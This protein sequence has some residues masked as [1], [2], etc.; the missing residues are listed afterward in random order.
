MA[1][2]SQQQE[3]KSKVNKRIAK[4][5]IA[6]YIRMAFAMLVSLYTSRVV[7][8][9]LGVEDFGTYGVVGGIV[10]L[11]A[12]V[13]NT[14]VGSTQRF[15][16]F[17]LGSKNDNGVT[18]V[19]SNAFH[20]QVFFSL[21]VFI[22]AETVGLY[23]LNH[24]I[25]V[26]EGRLNAANWVYQFSILITILR[27]L[28]SPFTASVVAYER[29]TVFAIVGIVNVILK[30]LIVYLLLVSPFDRLITYS[31]LGACV[32]LGVTC[33]YVYYNITRFKLCRVHHGVDKSLLKRMLS[34]SGWNIF[35][36]AAVLATFQGVDLIINYFLG[37]VV[38]AALTIAN[39]VYGA[40][41]SLTSNFQTA[42]NP[43]ITKTY[44][45]GDMNDLFEL[46]YR[47]T[48]YS[49]FLVIICAIPL[50]FESPGLLKLWLTTVP[51]YSIGFCRCLIIV[52]VFEAMS[53]P[54]WMS[55]HA[56]GKVKRYSVSVSLIL[57]LNFPLA[58]I[59][60]FF[61][62]PPISV[63]IVRVLV[64]SI[65]YFYR[66]RYVVKFLDMPL[67]DYLRNAIMPSIKVLIVS[68]IF[69][70]LIELLFDIHTI[71]MTILIF[72][73]N[74]TCIILIGLSINEREKMISMF[75]SKIKK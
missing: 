31:A 28:R 64:Y 13:N 73:I 39:Q 66:T 25:K 57:V 52:C 17:E 50:I 44:A 18:K 1:E 75:L 70:F 3:T 22:L 62:F 21:I 26:P 37:V 24:Y 69:S 35:G 29:M 20:V 65:I 51:E 33:F 63:L 72:I 2:D 23:Y 47:T 7:L 41:Y 59:V 11:F 46:I 16:N 36:S 49:F 15:L 12:F 56:T 14:L 74:V 8:Q 42:F 32:S 48:R 71:I 54:L 38:N 60:L 30:L 53:A 45:K 10:T 58:F 9:T 6:L 68:L 4:N 5:T 27:I 55:I 67:L 40:T 43:Q 19:F 61:Q 34:F